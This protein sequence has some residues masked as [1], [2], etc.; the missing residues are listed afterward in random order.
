[1]PFIFTGA[2]HLAI[3]SEKSFSTIIEILH[4]SRQKSHREPKIFGLPLVILS[5][6]DDRVVF[7]LKNNS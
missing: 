4:A 2:L 6:P 5:V 1:M 7:S 3:T